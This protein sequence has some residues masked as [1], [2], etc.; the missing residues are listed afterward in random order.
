MRLAIVLSL[1]LLACASTSEESAGLGTHSFRYS[2][3][4]SEGKPLLTGQLAFRF[5]DNSTVAGT[6]TIGWADGADTTAVV[7]PQIGSG[8]LVGTRRGAMLAIQLNPD[9]ADNNVGLEAIRTSRG[10]AGHWVWTAITGPRTS[11]RFAAERE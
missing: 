6:W 8:L 5:I 11:G 2:A 10:Y 3:L 1:L 7:G 9:Y 4:S